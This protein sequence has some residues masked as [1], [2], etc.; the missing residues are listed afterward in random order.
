MVSCIVLAAGE[1]KRF[2]SPKPLARI[3]TKTVIEIIQDKLLSS[4]LSEIIVVLGHKA[5][6]I[7]PFVNKNRRI[8]YT[9]NSNYVLG[10]TSSVKAGLIKVNPGS[11]G[12]MVLP[13]DMPAVSPDTIDELIHIFLEKSP[14]ILVPE[15]QERKGHPPIFSTKLLDELKNLSDI[16]PL[17]EILH[18]HQNSVLKIPV[19][20]RGVAASFNTTEELKELIPLVS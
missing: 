15:Y 12:I 8:S 3:G 7:I 6:C 9:I 2:G 14:L 4:G 19:E 17:S 13:V 20:D 16:E 11:K 5:D 10:Q 1:S 18:K